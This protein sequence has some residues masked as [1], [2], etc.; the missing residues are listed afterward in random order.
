MKRTR[1]RR[2]GG[3]KEEEEEEE[4]KEEKGKEE[5]SGTHFVKGYLHSRENS[6]PKSSQKSS[7]YQTI[8]QKICSRIKTITTLN[9]PNY[10]KSVSDNSIINLV[11]F[12]IFD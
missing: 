3:G 9:R 5:V 6:G 4:E 2:R 7:K 12:N 8:E 10:Q 11:N 1:R